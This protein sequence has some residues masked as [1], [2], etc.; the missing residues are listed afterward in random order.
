MWLLVCIHIICGWL[1]VHITYIQGSQFFSE[2]FSEGFFHFLP[3]KD[4]RFLPVFFRPK[5]EKTSLSLFLSGENWKKTFFL[6]LCLDKTG[7]NPYSI[8]KS[9]MITNCLQNRP[10]NGSKGGMW[11]ASP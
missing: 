8:Q 3:V 2:V 5:L 1:L 6:Q 10:R 7:R 11:H 4:M 9:H